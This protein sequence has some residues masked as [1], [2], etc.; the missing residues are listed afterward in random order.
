MNLLSL[1]FLVFG[2]VL[3]IAFYAVPKRFQW[4]VLL[5]ASMLFYGM[6]GI[7]NV[8]FIILLMLS[9]DHLFNV[10]I[11]IVLFSLMCFSVNFL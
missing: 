3:V 8:I 9:T 5:I 1:Q 11:S 6:S 4:W 10:I 2:I 7:K